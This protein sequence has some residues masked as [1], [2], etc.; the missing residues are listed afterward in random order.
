MTDSE[1][2]TPPTTS[3]QPNQPLDQEL[4]RLMEKIVIISKEKIDIEISEA[5]AQS[6]VLNLK[7]EITKVFA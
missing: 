6:E 2:S 1:A 4:D 3:N 7:N 5:K